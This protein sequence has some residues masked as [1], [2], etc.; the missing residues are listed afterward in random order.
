MYVFFYYWN[1]KL[2]LFFVDWI[3]NIL[4]GVGGFYCFIGFGFL[5]VL[6]F[7]RSMG[8]IGMGCLFGFFVVNLVVVDFVVFFL[9]IFW[10]FLWI[11][12]GIGMFVSLVF[13][14]NL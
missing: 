14:K 9:K 3:L 2:N 6:K 11:L 4:I 13:F 7:I 10:S 5:G 1:W 12:G 8:L